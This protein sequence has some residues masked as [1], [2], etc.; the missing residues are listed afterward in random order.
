MRA[1]LC[2]LAKRHGT[3]A[4][5]AEAMRSKHGT[6]KLATRG[7]VSAGIALRAARLPDAE[8]ADPS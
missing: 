2:F 4:K 8:A 5:L 6:V 7:A 3:L 1:A